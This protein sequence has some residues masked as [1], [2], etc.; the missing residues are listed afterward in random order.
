MLKTKRKYSVITRK[1]AWRIC[2]QLL[3]NAASDKIELYK[4]KSFLKKPVSFSNNDNAGHKSVPNVH[5]WPLKKI[6]FHVHF[7]LFV[8]F[9][10]C[11]CPPINLS[12]LLLSSNQRPEMVRSIVVLTA[13]RHWVFSCH[14]TSSFLIFKPLIPISFQD[15]SHT[16][17]GIIIIEKWLQITDDM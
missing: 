10:C 13:Y 1:K 8:H 9:R 15:S 11:Y 4:L 5:I 17:F 3:I 12:L 14:V 6:V 16:R 7:S 2:S